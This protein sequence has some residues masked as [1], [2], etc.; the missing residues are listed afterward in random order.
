MDTK[1]S[2]SRLVYELIGEKYFIKELKIKF[3]LETTSAYQKFI[4]IRNNKKDDISLSFHS[5]PA[6][7]QIYGSHLTVLTEIC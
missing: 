5:T 3:K 4:D 1:Y 7:N 6:S 2:K